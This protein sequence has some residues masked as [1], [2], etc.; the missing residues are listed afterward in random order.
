MNKLVFVILLLLL[1]GC[2]GGGL[3]FNAVDHREAAD[4]RDRTLTGDEGIACMSPPY[5]CI[6]GCWDAPLSCIKASQ[7]S[8]KDD[9]VFGENGY[10]FTFRND[11]KKRIFIRPCFETRGG[12][13]AYC[14][15]SK[16]INFILRP[17]KATTIIFTNT[18]VITKGVPGQQQGAS[19]NMYD[20]IGVPREYSL[21][22][23]GSNPS[24][25]YQCISRN[26]NFYDNPFE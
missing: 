5:P 24:E 19:T 4:S 16:N 3:D 14:V 6:T 26:P 10:R 2:S 1:A 23:A 17:G 9:P 13:N 20:Y 18:K 21:E 12:E 8:V 15:G 22:L 11:C 7:G 25:N